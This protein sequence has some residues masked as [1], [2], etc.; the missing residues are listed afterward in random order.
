M[1]K[2]ILGIVF[3]IST[4]CYADLSANNLIDPDSIDPDMSQ[5]MYRIDAKNLK[6]QQYSNGA[7][8]AFT[9][10]LCNTC[11]MKTYK[12]AESPSLLLNEAP[13][14]IGDLATS[15]LKKGFTEIQLGINRTNGTISYLYLGGV[16]ELNTHNSTQEP[17]NEI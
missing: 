5:V 14:K 13:L 7:P 8:S 11:K 6:I 3:F 1:H 10:K 15:I 16:S 9:L 4:Y 17:H 12:L 2:L